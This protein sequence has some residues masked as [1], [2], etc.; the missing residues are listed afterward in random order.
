MA[1]WASTIAACWT[2]CLSLLQLNDAASSSDYNKR[3]ETD[4]VND[5][6]QQLCSL[7]LSSKLLSSMGLDTR[8]TDVKNASM[9]MLAK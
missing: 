2:R 9:S 4:A 1:A 8:N 7:K 5:M 6:C 3:I